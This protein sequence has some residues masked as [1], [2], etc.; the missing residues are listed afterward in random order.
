MILGIYPFLLVI[1]SEIFN[2]RII[3]LPPAIHLFQILFPSPKH[4][5]SRRFL[6]MVFCS[7]ELWCSEL[8]CLFLQFG[9]NNFPSD[10]TFL[11]DLRRVADSSVSSAL[12]LFLVFF[13]GQSAYFSSFYQRWK[14]QKQNI[15][16]LFI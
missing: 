15:S 13:L 10:I 12:Y 3:T 8:T 11:L 9:A 14:I 4:F 7:G 2:F 16:N 5:L 6:L 1:L